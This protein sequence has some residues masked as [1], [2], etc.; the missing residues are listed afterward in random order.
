MLVPAAGVGEHRPKDGRV[1]GVAQEGNRPVRPGD[2]RPAR[3]AP[4]ERPVVAQVGEI[5]LGQAPQCRRAAAKPGA[6]VSAGFDELN[7]LVLAVEEG[8]ERRGCVVAE[9]PGPPARFSRESAGVS[10]PRPP[11]AM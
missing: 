3:M 8:R 10:N 4:A 9:R 2:I 1:D 7:R 5:I 11:A 6:D